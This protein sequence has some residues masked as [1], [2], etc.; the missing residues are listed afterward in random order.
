MSE[1]YIGVMSGTSLDGVD[2]ALC[3]I[4][5]RAC[6][7]IHARE[8]PFPSLLKEQ[9]LNAIATPLSIESFGL[10]DHKLGKLFAAT[11]SE[12]LEEFSLDA[13][14]INAIGLHGQTLWH[15]PKTQTPFSLQLGDANI[16]VA[17]NGI[18][19]VADFRR[20]DVANGGEGAP[21][22][23]LF[24]H[25]CFSHLKRKSAVINIGGMANITLIQ[26]PLLG[27]DSGCGNVLL[28]YWVEKSLSLPYDKEG[29]FAR[30]GT[31]HQPLLSR[32]LADS[33]FAQ[34][35]P[36]STGREHFNGVWLEKH[37]NSFDTIAAADVQRTLLELTARTI[38]DALH[39]HDIE[40]LIICG[41]GSKNS[42]LME[43]LTALSQG[44]VAPSDAFGV[45]SDAMEAMAFAW[46]AYKRHHKEPL[47][48]RSVTGATKKS[49]LGALYE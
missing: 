28:D 16:M 11:V 30:S 35:P 4:D 31:I 26:R 22:A 34:T 40:Q 13:S 1:L 15:A 46:L 42:F 12:F 43:R 33:Y 5:A 10:L 23:P 21:F 29:A 32:L 48:L 49:L 17:R 19:T 14:S 45:S 25:F 18:T 20:M 2:V 36:K 3:E 47:D 41:G 24:H 9:V 39:S 7:L 44:V 27:W 38:T 6:R 37:L 8:Y